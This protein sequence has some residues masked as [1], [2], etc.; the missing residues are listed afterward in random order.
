MNVLVVSQQY[1]PYPVVGALR[2]RKVAEMFRDR[3]HS[4]TVVT[5]RLKDEQSDIRLDDGRLRV[6]TVV[7]GL[8]YRLRFVAFRDR[9]RGRAVEL[10]SWDGPGSSTPAAGE[11]PPANGIQRA[12]R[13]LRS[14]AIGIL[15]LPDDQQHFVLPAYHVSREIAEQGVDLVYTTVPAF[16]THF[17]GLLLRRRRGVRWI[18]EFRDPWTTT[19]NEARRGTGAVLD[20]LDRWM[21]RQCLTHADVIVAVTGSVGRQLAAKLPPERRGRVV[22]AMNGIDELLPRRARGVAAGPYRI[23]YTGSFYHD[24]DPRPFLTA[25]AEWM[26]ARGLAP[27]EV[28]VDFAGRCRHYGNISVE[29]ITRE[30][31]LAGV[32]QFHD[33][34]PTAAVQE[35]LS[36]ADLV[37]LLARSQPAQ[38]PNKLF[39]YLGARVPILATVDRGGESERILREVGGQF[40]VTAP[41]GEPVTASMFR[42]ALE[43]AYTRRHEPL[44]MNEAALASLMTTRQFD[45]LATAL[46][47]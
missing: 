5:E 1:P 37:L 8:P 3:G 25:L 35:M 19:P 2:A 39:E 38:V 29:E 7:A 15:R 27:D 22:V 20:R 43:S 28:Q 46:G 16:S 9:L 23:V 42:D 14:F 18:A 21:E 24:R 4:V 36:R 34:L 41:D 26:R 33:W 45:H 32:V 47:V 31:G 6:R 12:M 40:V 30:L 13:A 44:P 10:S 17:V 11:G